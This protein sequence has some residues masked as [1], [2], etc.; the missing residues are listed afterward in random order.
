MVV[1]QILEELEVRPR[2]CEAV[3]KVM[4]ELDVLHSLVPRFESVIILEHSIAK[5][6]SV[7]LRRPHIAVSGIEVCQAMIEPILFIREIPQAVKEIE[8]AFKTTANRRRH[9]HDTTDAG[10]QCPLCK[11]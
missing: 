7:A 5:A 1:V 10:L 3:T 9:L 11:V 4:M 2:S 6:A 8:R